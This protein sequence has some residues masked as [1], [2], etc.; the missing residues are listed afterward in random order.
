M[1][2][3]NKIY[4]D[5]KIKQLLGYI[6][7]DFEPKKCPQCKCKKIITYKTF[8]DDQGRVDEYWVKCSRCGKHLGVW[9]Y[10]SW[11]KGEL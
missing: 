7:K 2:R 11:V 8:L 5:I 4:I 1:I 6:G 9:A 3:I 10:G